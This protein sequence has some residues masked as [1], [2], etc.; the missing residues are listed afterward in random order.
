MSLEAEIVLYLTGRS[1]S[2]VGVHP[3]MNPLSPG[4]HKILSISDKLQV[5][6]SSNVT[7]IFSNL[8]DF[9]WGLLDE[10]GFLIS[11]ES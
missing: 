9:C 3:A 8:Y 1:T 2:L 5:G 6:S 11:T 10:K 7:S 4:P